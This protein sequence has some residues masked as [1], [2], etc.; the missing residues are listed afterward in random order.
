METKGKEK[1]SNRDKDA[2][3][4][5]KEKY[6]WKKCINIIYRVRTEKKKIKVRMK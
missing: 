5:T 2:E 6:G 3:V 4:K 1:I